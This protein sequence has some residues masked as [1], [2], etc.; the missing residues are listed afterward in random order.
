MIRLWKLECAVSVPSAESER[1]H[2]A[3]RLLQ[4]ARVTGAVVRLC[5]AGCGLHTAGRSS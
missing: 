1:R 2:A 4:D 3:G 5:F